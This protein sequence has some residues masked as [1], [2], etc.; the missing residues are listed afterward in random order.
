MA[1]TCSYGVRDACKSTRLPPKIIFT[2]FQH[3]AMRGCRY[4][5][6]IHA[7][8]NTPSHQAQSTDVA[9]SRASRTHSGRRPD[10]SV[11]H[12]TSQSRKFESVTPPLGVQTLGA[13]PQHTRLGVPTPSHERETCRANRRVV[14]RFTRNSETTPSRLLRPRRRQA[15]PSVKTLPR[16]SQNSKRRTTR[17][18]PARERALNARRG[19]RW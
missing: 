12:S 14:D 5:K 2:E 13:G 19:T 10:H 1:F 18:A 8:G 17:S 11:H 6:L 3:L 9:V 4:V 16:K 15:S 7:V